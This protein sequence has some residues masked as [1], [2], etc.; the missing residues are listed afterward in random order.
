[1][2]SRPLVVGLVAHDAMKEVLSNWVMQNKSALLNLRFYATGTTA[3]ILSSNHPELDISGLKSGPLGG[4][5][6]LGALICEGQLDALV[7][8]QDPMTAQPH[9]VDVKALV[10]MSTLYDVPLACN[11]STANLMITSPLFLRLTEERHQE[12]MMPWDAYMTRD[13]H[14]NEL[15]N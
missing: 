13:V 11:P 12:K 8:F 7:F 10:R 9:D 6:Q 3:K 2:I 14:K 5:Q 1:M 4:D 15:G